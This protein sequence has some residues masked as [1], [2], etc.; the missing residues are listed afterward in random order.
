MK[1]LITGTARKPMTYKAICGKV[2]SRDKGTY[3]YTQEERQLRITCPTCREAGMYDPDR[4]FE[5]TEKN[6]YGFNER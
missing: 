3:A 4:G 6:I 5:V 1:H 2:I